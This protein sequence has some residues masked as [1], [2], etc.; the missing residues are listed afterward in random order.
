MFATCFGRAKRAYLKARHWLPFALLLILPLVRCGQYLSQFTDED[1]EITLTYVSDNSSTFQFDANGGYITVQF[2]ADRFV[3]YSIRYGADCTGGT[4]AATLPQSGT[5]GA[6]ITV[7]ARMNYTELMANS[8]KGLICVADKA[9]YKQAS[10]T[11]TFSTSSITNYVTQYNETN[12]ASGAAL[13]SGVSGEFQMFQVE[14]TSPNWSN[15]S[16]N[17][18]GGT[19]KQTGVDFN[20]G[21]LMAIDVNDG[22]KQ[23]FFVVDRNNHRI[24]IFNSIPL[25]NAVNPDI[26]VGQADFTSGGSATTATSFNQPTALA[27][28]SDG[29]MFVADSQNNRVA[30]YNR[31]PT[32]NGSAMDFVLGQANFTTG[33]ATSAT[34]TT[35]SIP[36]G[37][38]CISS[39]LYIVDRGYHRIVVHTPVPTANTAAAFAIGQ[40]NLTSGTLGTDY[41]TTPYLNEPVQV[42]YTGSQ[43]IITEAFN[44]RA[45]VFNSLPT[46]AGAFPVYRIG[47]LLITDSS[48]NQGG[49]N[50]NQS[51]LSG[52]RGMAYRSGKLA[53]A[54]TNNHRIM[55]FDLPITANT[56][57]AT[58]QMGQPDF[59]TGT[60]PGTTAKG[61]FNSPKDVL[62]DG[63]YIRVQDRGN[64][65]MQVLALPF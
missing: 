45:V 49:V 16:V 34:A 47:Q 64:N 9:N 27:V 4:L 36:Y 29:K 53:I 65:R 55:F 54:D 2:Y 8:G 14:Q 5:A 1:R 22:Y 33:T 52:P 24:L 7:A 63:S 48:A 41:S 61:T 50:P 30:G 43:F 58:H 17:R 13:S 42:L 56:P 28:C 26:V 44:N 37:V 31:V 19:T 38:S 11:K 57:N 59:S 35:L 39:R 32:A 3:N 51:S 21:M 25:S 23:K 15:N 20:Y 10:L 40:A 62:F 18:D 46:A 6:N 60:V 12:G